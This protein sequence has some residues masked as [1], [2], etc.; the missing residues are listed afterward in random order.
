MIQSLVST[1]K[2]DPELV[3]RLDAYPKKRNLVE[4]ER[5]GLVSEQEVEEMIRLAA[6][7]RQR[8]EG[9]LRTFHPGLLPE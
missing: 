9:W 7:L 3:D 5:A 8:V 4:Y 1:L 6:S 2:A